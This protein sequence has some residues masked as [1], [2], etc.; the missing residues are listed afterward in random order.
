[1]TNDPLADPHMELLSLAVPCHPVI[2]HLLEIKVLYCPPSI[3]EPLA[4]QPVVLV[5]EVDPVLMA[6][7][8]T[9][10]VAITMMPKKKL[11]TPVSPVP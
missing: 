5:P 11:Q 4:L 7:L 10:K 3:M 2:H 9:M 1:M 6:N 8:Q